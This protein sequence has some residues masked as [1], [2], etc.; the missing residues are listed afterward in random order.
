MV[1]VQDPHGDNITTSDIIE[2]H[3]RNVSVHL[4]DGDDPL[5]NHARVAFK[6]C[7]MLSPRFPTMPPKYP[8]D[9]V[10]SLAA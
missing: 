3:S 9:A 5:R 10:C 1:C 8:I 2:D 6:Q 4:V 7:V